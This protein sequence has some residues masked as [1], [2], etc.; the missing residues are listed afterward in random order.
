MTGAIRNL[1]GQ[2]LFDA[3]AGALSIAH[4]HAIARSS[5]GPPPSLIIAG[6]VGLALLVY[7]VLCWL[8][9]F[10]HC[11]W[12]DGGKWHEPFS[13]KKRWRRCSIC[14]GTNQRLRGGRRLYNF[15]RLRKDDAK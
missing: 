11:R 10:T 3:L 13:K 6:F 12:C 7:V 5:D 8:F 15:L 4:P 2:R 14:R 9:P 1:A